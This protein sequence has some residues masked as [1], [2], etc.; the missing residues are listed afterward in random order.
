MDWKNYEEITKYIYETLGKET[1]VKIV[2]YGNTCKVKGKSGVSHQVDVLTSHSNGVHDYQTAIEC[3]YWKKKIDKDI[4]MKV[5]E[6]IED[7]GIN[8]GVIVSKLGFTKDG[9]SFA[10]YKNIGLVELREIGERD[11]KEQKGN[12]NFVFGELIVNNKIERIRPEIES[13]D[14]DFVDPNLKLEKINPNLMIM[15]LKDGNEFLLNKYLMSFKEELHVNEQGKSL[16]KYYEIE[17][18][19]L[20]NKVTKEKLQVRGLKLK[21]K[22]MVKNMDSKLHFNLVDEV[23]L[24]MKLHF[25]QRSFTISKTGLIKKDET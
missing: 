10:E 16:E 14:F 23:W 6:I 12:P 3:K 4:V 8:K 11:F 2:G 7:A 19:H 9:I 13:I 18:A 1:G 15:R 24:I 17:G 22:L 25:E 21:G 5:A 20:I